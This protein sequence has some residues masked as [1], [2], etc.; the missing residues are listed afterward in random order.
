MSYELNFHPN[1]LDEWRKLDKSVRDQFKKKLAERLENPMVPG[2]QLS[3]QKD[4]FKIKLRNAGYRLVYEVRDKQL[5]VLVV[6]VGKRERNAVY[7]AA[8]HRS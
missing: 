1:A 2:S 3:G 6:A 7:K 5:V 4:R 8:S